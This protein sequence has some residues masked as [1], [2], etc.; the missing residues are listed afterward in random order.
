MILFYRFSEHKEAD[1][2]CSYCTA[3]LRLCFRMG[4]ISVFSCRGS[5]ISHIVKKEGIKIQELIQLKLKAQP[6]WERKN[7]RIYDGVEAE[8]RKSQTK[9]SD[10]S[11][12]IRGSAEDET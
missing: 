3:D 4:E 7:K 9:F 11:S 8:T 12:L 6:K 5:V 2:P 10:Y 1:Q